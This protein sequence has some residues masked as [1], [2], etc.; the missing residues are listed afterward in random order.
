VLSPRGRRNCNCTPAAH[1]PGSKTRLCAFQ[2]QRF[3]IA[4]PDKYC[5]C[6]AQA[7]WRAASI[8]ARRSRQLLREEAP[9]RVRQPQTWRLTPQ[10]VFAWLASRSFR[11]ALLRR[12]QKC[13]LTAAKMMKPCGLQSVMTE[14]QPSILSTL[15]ST[16]VS[17]AVIRRLS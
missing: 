2:R 9:G 7:T 15:L 10:R 16:A 5:A 14:R 1:V 13:T 4:Q 12:G 6:P 3:A 8:L 11:P 17:T